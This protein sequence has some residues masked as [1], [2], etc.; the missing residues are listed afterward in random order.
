M[1]FCFSLYPKFLLILTGGWVGG[2]VLNHAP[3]HERDPPTAQDYSVDCNN[4]WN[5][6]LRKAHDEHK[7]GVTL[8]SK[9]NRKINNSKNH[10]CTTELTCD[11]LLS[12]CEAAPEIIHHGQRKDELSLEVRQLVPPV[13]PIDHVLWLLEK[14]EWLPE[15][16]FIPLVDSRRGKTQQFA[17]L[18]LTWKIFSASSSFADWTLDFRVSYCRMAAAPKEHPVN[19]HGVS[20]QSLYCAKPQYCTYLLYFLSFWRKEE[21]QDIPLLWTWVVWI[22]MA[23]GLWDGVQDLV[24]Q[25]Q[26][27]KPWFL[28]WHFLSLCLVFWLPDGTHTSVGGRNLV[29][30][31]KKKEEEE[32][33]L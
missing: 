5:T 14:Q 11:S 22:V 1:S 25:P 20:Y 8:N 21:W 19:W 18:N 29:F 6:T 7:H 13:M 4:A 17:W 26:R 33:I 15:S 16:L 24:C 30:W 2:E 27:V 10:V 23:L 31:K 12:I 32:Q 28:G 9:K 3:L